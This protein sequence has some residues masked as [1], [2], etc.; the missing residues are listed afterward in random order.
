MKN[1]PLILGILALLLSITCAARE[2]RSLWAPPWNL[3]SPEQIDELV[4]DAVQNNQTEILAEVRYRADALYIPNKY[5]ADFYNPEPRSSSLLDNDFDP[6]EYLLNQAHAYD[7]DVQA[8]VSV[9]CATPTNTEKLY[10]NY[11]Y[12][13]HP[14]WIMT[15]THGN[16]MNGAKYMGHFIDPGNPEVKNYLLNVV[17][18]IVENYP[19]LDGIHLDYI[20]YPDRNIGYNKESV[21]RYKENNDLND[22]DWNDWRKFQVT[23][24][25]STLKDRARMINPR[26]LITA[27]VI[28]NVEEAEADYAQDWVGWLNKGIIDRAY[29][30]AYAKKYSNF[31][32]IV[33]EIGELTP[34]DS[35]VIGLRAWQENYP[36]LDYDVQQIID[37]ATLCRQ[38]GFA[39]IALF[40]YDS[41]KKT[42]F[43]SKLTAA[44]FNQQ[45]FEMYGNDEDMFI[46]QITSTYHSRI[47]ADSL[48]ESDYRRQRTVEFYNESDSGNKTEHAK[49]YCD[50]ISYQ[51]EQYYISFFFALSNVW[52]WEI[53]DIDNKLVFRKNSTYQKGYYVDVWDGK[54]AD[55]EN[56]SPGI[57]TL[58]VKDADNNVISSKKFILN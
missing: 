27:A 6:L 29:P 42:N 31:Y 13:N 8:W 56:I 41:I 18:D 43:F 45:D 44:L 34:A 30:M 3:T 52:T 5:K 48:A 35:V 38:M 49:A 4:T 1:K 40:S 57:F 47:P 15:D 37:K 7:L 21:Q 19:A 16:R 24:F 36:R 9:L 54:A 22:I 46:T 14:G 51:N 55:G 11:I 26:I 17:L 25:I 39:G 28:A 2:I 33:S 50:N 53:I 20:R 32:R 12:Q 58:S 10:S 23:D